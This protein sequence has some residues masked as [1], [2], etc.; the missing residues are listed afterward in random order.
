M[1]ALNITMSRSRLCLL[2]VS[3]LIF[4][5]TACGGGGSSG[6]GGGSVLPTAP[7]VITQTNTPKVAGAAVNTIA[8][9]TSLP[10]AVQTTALTPA[11]SAVS[12]AQMLA[13]IGITSARKSFLQ[14]AAPAIVTGVMITNNCLVSGTISAP[15]AAPTTA[16]PGVITFTN[17]SDVTGITFNGTLSVSNWVALTAPAFSADIVFN[18]TVVTT[19]PA[20]TL[21]VTGD[22]HVSVDSLSNTTISGSSLTITNTLATLGNLGIKNYSITHDALRNLTAMTFQFAS[23]AIGGT[24]TFTM[25]TPFKKTAPGVYPSSGS[26]TITG[27]S[28]TVLRITALGNETAPVGSQV[29]MELSTDGGVTYAA[30]TYST[31]AI[32]TN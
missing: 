30:P 26:A 2:A 14:G 12:N 22:M 11:P 13:D 25:I 1:H 20:N 27:A 15:Q 5:L 16:T 18:L 29:M 4:G 9:S 6:A 32:I 19:T 10:F 7:V 21:T 17:C 8:K 24:A 28:S 23:S 3:S 31:W